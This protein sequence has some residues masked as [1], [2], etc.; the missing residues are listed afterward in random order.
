MPQENI[1]SRR[2]NST[3]ERT[4][5]KPWTPPLEKLQGLP[6]GEPLEPALGKTEQMRADVR[7]W[8]APLPGLLCLSSCKS[9]APSLCCLRLAP[10]AGDGQRR[11]DKGFEREQG[12]E[13]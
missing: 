13:L 8:K 10:L 7:L 3:P 11:R 5:I 1:S 6:A 4:T 2:W 12:H 9:P